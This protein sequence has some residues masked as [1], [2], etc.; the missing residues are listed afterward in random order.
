MGAILLG[1][2]ALIAVIFLLRAFVSTDP[3]ALVKA[4]RTVGSGALGLG[5][6]VGE[7]LTGSMFTTEML[8]M[9]SESRKS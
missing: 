8:K 2:V 3:K 7:R 6:G 5:G 4:L 9:L 1:I